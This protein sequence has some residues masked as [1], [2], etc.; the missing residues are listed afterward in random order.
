[1]KIY[2]CDKS[3]M[4]TDHL[5]R[6]NM[7]RFDDATK[8]R[9]E[10][11]RQ[12]EDRHRALIREL[13]LQEIL[14][15]TFPGKEARIEENEYG[16]PMVAGLYDEDGR[17]CGKAEYAGF[18]FSISHS[19]DIIIIA[20]GERTEGKEQ[21]ASFMEGP[22]G[23]DVERCGRVRDY[24]AILR[25]FTKEE[26]ELIT[27]SR[28]PEKEFYR[29]WTYREAFSKEEGIGLSLFEK[30]PVA[31]DYKEKRV[32]YHGRKLSFHEYD[33]PGYQITLCCSASSLYRSLRPA[34]RDR[35]I[36]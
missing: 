1:M 6:E 33:Y 7:S 26:Q 20:F 8:Q 18:D 11:F 10:R 16:K 24:K 30:E 12:E 34:L 15:E 29:V 2:L 25:F 14:R 13:M 36:C 31:I 27:G 32:I 17:P 3:K 9:I 5:Y 19:G 23:I 22:L 21:T 4:N 35:R 28:D